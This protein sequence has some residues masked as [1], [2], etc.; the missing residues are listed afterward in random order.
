MRRGRVMASARRQGETGGCGASHYAAPT[1][2]DGMLRVG[3]GELRAALE[4]FVG[5]ERIHSFMMAGHALSGQVTSWT[6]ATRA[7]LG[8]L[9]EARTTRAAVPAER[10]R[11]GEIRNAS[12]VIHLAEGDPTAALDTL[13]MVLS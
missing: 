7:R 10:A 4:Q 8:M 3:R 11:F 9:D 13:Q 1:S 6:I 2:G 12:A 5:A